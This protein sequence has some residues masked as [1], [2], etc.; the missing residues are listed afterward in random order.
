MKRKVLIARNA[1]F[2][3]GVKRAVELA[4]KAVETN[5]SGK[6]IFSLGRLVHNSFV[7]E[8]LEKLGVSVVASLAEIQESGYLII[9]AHGVSPKIFA[10][11]KSKKQNLIDTTCVWVRKVQD[12]A[13]K[14]SQE[15][16]QVVIVGDKDHPEVR[17]V[18]EWAGGQAIV[19][20]SIDDIKNL[21]KIKKTGLLA[22]TTQSIEG[23]Q[24]I[25]Q[26]LK[27][28]I[29]NL[30]IFNTICGATE[31][32][33]KAAMELAGQVGVMFVIGDE[34]SANTRRLYQLCSQINPKTFFIQSVKDLKP[35]ML[36]SKKI[37]GLTAGASTPD[38]I[39]TEV[40]QKIKDENF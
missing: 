33:Q 17:G 24:K 14:L 25:A 29:K 37:I 11:V 28:E 7:V 10:E 35:Q 3:E 4:T 12:L 19:I 22:Q 5:Q 16:Y 32:R 13:Q 2:C 20:E 27:K 26:I 15:N 30:T 36:E 18:V 8:K 34:A 1:G 38:W 40:V 31:K 21:D 23:F 9:S 39:I 6:K